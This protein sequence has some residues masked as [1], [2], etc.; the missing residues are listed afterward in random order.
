MDD[1][2]IIPYEYQLSSSAV[3]WYGSAFIV[4]DDETRWTRSILPTVTR[5]A[6]STTALFVGAAVAS[7]DLECDLLGRRSG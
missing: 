5:H 4:A 6:G 3:G 7:V 1:D 2:D